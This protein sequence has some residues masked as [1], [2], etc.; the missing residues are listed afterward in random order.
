MP[1]QTPPEL[2]L[3]LLETPQHPTTT[4]S[5]SDCPPWCPGLAEGTVVCCVVLS[6]YNKMGCIFF[7]LLSSAC[8]ELLRP[9]QSSNMELTLCA[10]IQT[11]KNQRKEI[12]MMNCLFSFP[13][14]QTLL[15]EQIRTTGQLRASEGRTALKWGT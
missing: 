8:L 12:E 4:P 13:A 15:P 3:V 7:F 11:P 9:P 6:L 10:P 1:P 5:L 14:Q 2:P